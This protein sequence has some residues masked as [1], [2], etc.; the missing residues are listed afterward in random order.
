M[1]QILMNFVLISILSNY[2]L[3]ML[4]FGAS[5]LKLT[6][7]CKYAKLQYTFRKKEKK[8]VKI[9]FFLPGVVW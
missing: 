7:L 3:C 2:S 6:L 9:S 5:N 1:W 8:P 4:V